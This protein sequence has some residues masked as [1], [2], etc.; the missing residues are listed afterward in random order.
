[1][2]S[3]HAYLIIA[4]E[5]P[6]MLERLVEAL[7]DPR[8]DIFVHIDK[9]ATFD[10]SSLSTFHSSLF[11]IPSIDAR[12]GDYSLVEVELKLIEAALQHGPYSYLHLL[13]DSDYP[14]KSQDYI[15]AECERLAGKEFIGYAKTLDAEKE[16]RN[17]VQYYYFFTKRFRENTFLHRAYKYLYVRVQKYLGI[18]R[19]KHIDFKRGSQWCS[20]TGEFATYVMEHRHEI[21]STYRRTYC[22]DEIFIQTLCL[23]SPFRERLYC[24]TDEFEGC[25]RYVNWHGR[26]I[27]WF[28]EQDID[29]MMA[30]NRWFARKFKDE[31]MSLVDKVRESI[32]TCT[33][34]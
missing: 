25:K 19:S 32:V 24:T 18:K 16:I 30:S 9:K 7:D 6:L 33:N 5:Q 34:E 4:Y 10:G 11:T 22:P 21:Q 17:K 2:A 1:M 8:N 26:D 3:R 29:R 14:I 13:S 27:H 20:I 31:Q 28:D 23:A 12:W 15:H